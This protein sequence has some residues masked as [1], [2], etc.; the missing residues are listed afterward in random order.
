LHRTISRTCAASALP[1]VIGADSPSLRLRLIIR[2]TVDLTGAGKGNSAG[3]AGGNSLA[4]LSLEGLLTRI[5]AL[6]CF[7]AFA[8]SAFAQQTDNNLKAEQKDIGKLQTHITKYDNALGVVNQLTR[9]AD[10]NAE[11]NG[12][13]FFQNGSK[14]ISWS[15]GPARTCGLYCNVN[16]TVGGCN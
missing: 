2:E 15:C 8:N 4:R 12:L 3:T 10:R 13:C 14:N 6:L 7:L 16:P 11:C 1:S 5:A 9:S